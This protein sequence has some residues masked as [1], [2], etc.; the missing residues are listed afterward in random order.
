MQL[1]IKNLKAKMGETEILRGVD[2]EVREGEVVALMGPNGSGKST[3]AQVI[4]G[5]PA[6]EVTAG[7]V[8]YEGQ[9]LLA[10]KPEERARAGVFLAWQYPQTIAGVSIGHF[11]RLAYQAKTGEKIA[12]REFVLWLKEKLDLVGLP[13]EM[14][15]RNVNEGLS[16]G[17]KKRVEMLQLAVL[18]P[19]LAILDETDSGLDMDA[20]KAVAQAVR[21][22]RTAQPGMSL[23]VI[24]HYS[25]LLDYLPADRVAV[26]QQGRIVAEGGQ[27]ETLRTI[28]EEGYKAFN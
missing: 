5:Q 6:Y 10:L 21:T 25:R 17:E 12:A 11:L 8:E 20:L 23:L 16:G 9:D 15:R 7:A 26:M 24:T 28:E 2:L 13:K 3:L 19:R 18:S 4:M 1:K 27:A 14:M 22:I